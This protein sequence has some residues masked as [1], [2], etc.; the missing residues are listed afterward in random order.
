[1]KIPTSLK[2]TAMAIALASI[3]PMQ[4][5]HAFEFDTGDSDIKV[6]WNNT[7][8]YSTAYRLKNAD[9][10]LLASGYPSAGP[11]DFSGYNL[12]DG[13][14]NFRTRGIVSSRIDWLSGLD[15]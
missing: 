12:D 13:N 14:R 1:M 2:P 5:A 7:F 15:V 3:L 8:K 10:G 6:T 11:G 4:A 9:P